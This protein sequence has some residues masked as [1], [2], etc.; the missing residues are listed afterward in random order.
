[1]QCIGG[2]AMRF[3]TNCGARLADDWK[4][5][6]KC[7]QRLQEIRK[8][9]KQKIS[10]PK[11]GRLFEMEEMNWGCIDGTFDVLISQTWVIYR[12]GLVISYAS[13]ELSGDSDIR[14]SCLRKEEVQTLCDMLSRFKDDALIDRGADGI[15]YNMIVYDVEGKESYKIMGYIGNTYSEKLRDFVKKIPGFS[16]SRLGPA[17]SKFFRPEY[18][19]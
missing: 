5:C 3:C 16:F 10:L 12:I 1:M 8:P 19:S 17:V 14:A 7:G 2:E 18:F 4:F 13:Y 9:E 6:T 11:D 15:G